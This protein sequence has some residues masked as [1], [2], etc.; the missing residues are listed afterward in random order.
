M[1]VC[2]VLMLGALLLPAAGAAA[3]SSPRAQAPLPAPDFLFGK[4][5]A[6]AGV[7]GGWLFARAGSDWYDFV[8]SNLTLENRDFNRPAI[9]ADVGIAIAPRMEALISV[10]FGQA[11]RLSEYRDFVDN[12][13]LPI[14]QTTQLSHTNL[15]GGVKVYLTERGREVSRLA[16]VPRTAVPY[17]GGGAGILWYRMEQRGDFVDFQDDSI[18][19][20]VF[21]SEGVTPSAHLFGGV[22]IKVWRRMYVTLDARY[23]WAAGDLGRDWIDFDPIDL[24]GTRVSAGLNFVF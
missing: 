6:S 11:T 12:D 14:E 22:D 19:G 8:T 17:V 9:G 3:Q 15:G 23:L 7:R 1:R 16:W 4:P 2:T 21:R 13:R 20:D 18:F 5:K 24:T 10:D